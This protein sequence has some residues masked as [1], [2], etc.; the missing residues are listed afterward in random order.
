MFNK[1]FHKLFLSCKE[2]TYYMELKENNQLNNLQL[3][4]YNIH[5][6]ICKYCK[7]YQKKRDLIQNYLLKETKILE[8]SNDE[9]I[10]DHDKIKKLKTKISESI[11]NQD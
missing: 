7:I 3:F 5:L 11:F 1:I 8:K 6:L 4:R 2:V 9:V 10:T